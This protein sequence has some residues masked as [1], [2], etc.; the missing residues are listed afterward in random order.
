MKEKLLSP[1][2]IN[3]KFTAQ[4]LDQAWYNLSTFDLSTTINDFFAK[5]VASS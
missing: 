2:V 4:V 3:N 1:E 5:Y